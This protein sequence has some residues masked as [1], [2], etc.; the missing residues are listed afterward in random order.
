[1]IK[2]IVSGRV[3]QDAELK[4]VGDTTVC[5]F[6]VAHTEKVYGPNPSEKTVWIQANIWGERA[7]KLKPYITK[8]TYVV[9]EGAGGLSVYTQKNGE[10]AGMINCRVSSLEF[11]G[12]PT[13]EPTPI[14]APPIGKVNMDGDLPF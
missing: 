2:L 4:T 3:G 8:G 7:E 1:M 5:S 10:V 6:S 14:T 13:A 9:V 11:G 12:K